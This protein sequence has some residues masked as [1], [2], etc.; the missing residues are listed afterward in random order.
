M[1]N[2]PNSKAGKTR[3]MISPLRSTI[4]FVGFG[5]DIFGHPAIFL[6]HDTLRHTFTAVSQYCPVFTQSVFLSIRS[7]ATKPAG[8][9]LESKTSA[10][11]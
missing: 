7:S 11:Q 10:D 4:S 5:K 1:N 8:Q 6:G 2:Y 9:V 3:R